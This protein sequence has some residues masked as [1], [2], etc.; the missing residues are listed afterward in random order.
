MSAAPLWV[1]TATLPRPFVLMLVAPVMVLAT[2]TRIVIPWVSAA[3]AGV[4]AMVIVF[5]VTLVS[6][7]EVAAPV[8]TAAIMAGSFGEMKGAVESWAMLS[9][10]TVDWPLATVIAQSPTYPASG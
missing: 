6:V 1:F 4:S 3:T 9:L 2:L 5:G 7:A 10:V 8:W